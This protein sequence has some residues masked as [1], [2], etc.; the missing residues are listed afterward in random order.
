MSCHRQ[1]FMGF[2]PP[3]VL[4][5]FS[6]PPQI[7]AFKPPRCEASSGT[8]KAALFSNGQKLTLRR[9]PPE[10]PDTAVYIVCPKCHAAYVGNALK[11]SLKVSCP[12]CGTVF[13]TSPSEL[14]TEVPVTHQD[15]LETGNVVCKHM[16]VCSGCSVP[17]NVSNP[18]MLEDARQFLVKALR[19]PMQP[20]VDMGPTHEWRTHAK[21]AIRRGVRGERVVIGLFKAHSHNI[22]AIPGCSVHA[23]E[24]ER[25]VELVR[26]VLS[27]GNVAPYDEATNSGLVRYALFTV[28]RASRLVQV[29]LVWNAASW[30]D[31]APMAQQTG[32]ELW[33]R[34][35]NHLHSLWFNWNTSAT[36]VIVNPERERYY[37]MFGKRDLQEEVCGVS[38]KFPPYVFRQANLDA[39]EKMLLPKLLAYIPRGSSVAEFCAGVGVIGL[40]G[41]KAGKIRQLKAS[42][43][44]GSVEGE[45]WDAAKCLLRS[46]VKA[47]IDFVVGSDDETTDII[48]RDTNV[49]I[50]DPP[51]AGLSDF[52]VEYLSKIEDTFRLRRIIYVSCN[53]AALKKNA[54]T[55]CE[56]GQW[57]LSAAHFYI[58]FPGSDQVETLAIFDR[59]RFHSPSPYLFSKSRHSDEKTKQSTRDNMRMKRTVKKHSKYYEVREASNRQQ[60]SS[61]RERTKLD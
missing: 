31:A 45:F 57:K 33:R 39:F 58:L 35:K 56:G 20:T 26:S 14:Y 36:N 15:S 8:R 5:F 1:N 21:L 24:I 28:E 27:A 49:A 51:R 42:E 18:P 44:Q 61:N 55:L 19:V 22:M 7:C 9:A 6:P 59:V 52:V 60:T 50:F 10:S 4:K 34:G 16:K 53:F 41:V 11:E 17:K 40:A 23:P 2:L 46:G 32:T 54:R 37:H 30:K 48:E 38:I 25:A 29:T 47:D 13:Q 12:S 3:T 43:I